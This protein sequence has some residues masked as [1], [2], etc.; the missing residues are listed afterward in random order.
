MSKKKVSN[1]KKEEKNNSSKT[2]VKTEV[3]TDVKTEK[4][5]A[6]IPDESES[7]TPKVIKPQYKGLGLK[8]FNT[9]KVRDTRPGDVDIN[10]D[11]IK[12]PQCFCLRLPGDVDVDTQDLPAYPLAYEMDH[13]EE[14]GLM[15]AFK[16]PKIR[17]NERGKVIGG[18]TY[19]TYKQHTAVVLWE[20]ENEVPIGLVGYWDSV[21][22]TEELQA[23][24]DEKQVKIDA[25]K[26]KDEEREQKKKD[27]LKA[28]KLKA[29]QK[30]ADA[31]IAE[32]E[33]SSSKTEVKTDEKSTDK[34][35]EKSTKKEEV[36]E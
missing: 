11:Q 21:P 28:D 9:W 25:K 34:V 4:V 24:E 8:D 17:N 14:T 7:K 3:K 23:I 5:I 33:K 30:A 32:N 36:K 35:D 15:V 22:T 13:F 16:A 1:D 19:T 20:R 6:E 31:I 26:K 27:K 12:T 10:G 29:D 18:D 2:E